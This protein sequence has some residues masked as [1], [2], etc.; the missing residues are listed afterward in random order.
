MILSTSNKTRKKQM[1]ELGVAYIC[2]ICKCEPVH[3]G[4]AL[5]LQLDHINGKSGDHRLE[6][7]RFLCPNCH[8]QTDTY[9]SRNRNGNVP[10]ARAFLHNLKD[11]LTQYL[12]EKTYPEICS[13]LNIPAHA[14]RYL[15]K[16]LN[17]HSIPLLLS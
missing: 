1:L 3:C 2:A 15:L 10:Q 7:L 12:S 13:E 14:L 16:E 4:K 9:V 6:N 17:I 11:Q 5:V 8:S